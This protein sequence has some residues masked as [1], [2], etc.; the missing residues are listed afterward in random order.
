MELVAGAPLA[1]HA[2]GMRQ[3]ANLRGARA[4][5]KQRQ[6]D[7]ARVVARL[8][9]RTPEARQFMAQQGGEAAK[10]PTLNQIKQARVS[11]RALGA[12]ASTGPP[13]PAPAAPAP[14]QT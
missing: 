2:Q 4:G 14:S 5:A 3:L 1:C 13:T 7:Q 12:D 9:R 8:N 10:Q 11:E 6:L